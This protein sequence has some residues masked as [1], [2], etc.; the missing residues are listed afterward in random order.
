LCHR[1]PKGPPFPASRSP[2][3]HHGHRETPPECGHPFGVRWQ[4]EARAPTPLSE[5]RVQAAAE[6][7]RRAP[8]PARGRSESGVAAGSRNSSALPPHSKGSAPS[9]RRVHHSR[10]SNTEY[11]RKDHH[12]F[13]R[14]VLI[15]RADSLQPPYRAKSLSHFLVADCSSLCNKLVCSA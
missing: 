12:C 8:A 11:R 7:G 2:N 6:D 14:E 15:K 3:R 13:G 10:E 9:P 5:G 4:S 1:T